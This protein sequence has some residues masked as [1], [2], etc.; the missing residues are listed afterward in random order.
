MKGFVGK[1]L[2]LII[3]VGA[4]QAAVWRL[5]DN[6][7][8]ETFPNKK[9][10]DKYIEENTDLL[11]FIDSTNFFT[12]PMDQD[13]R[14]ISEM[15]RSRLPGWTMG[16]LCTGAYH[17]GIYLDFA[18]YILEKGYRPKAMILC[19]NMRSLS[20][21]WDY[22]P[23]YQFERQRMILRKSN[24][25][26]RIFR[27]PMVV[28]SAPGHDFHS[29]GQVEYENMPV[30]DGSKR[31]GKVRDFRGERYEQVTLEN[32][33]RMIQ[34]QYMYPLPDDHRKILALR[35][36]GDLLGQAGVPCVVYFTPIDYAFCENFIGPR[37]REKLGK[38]IARIQSLLGDTSLE[39]IDLSFELDSPRFYWKNF[40][41]PNEHLNENG[42]NFVAGKVAANVLEILKN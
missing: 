24:S 1:I 7:A 35:K 11:L 9:I 18:Q 21:E 37:F 31:I 17:P 22:N 6:S 30:Y 15:V 25:L 26:A 8:L 3:A 36:I 32:M 10:L 5:G 40:F 33:T 27:R 41:Y 2:L 38:D 12:A 14:S 23:A 20:L 39:F 19:L 13:S 28:F 34:F 4:A 42:R 29:I 16:T